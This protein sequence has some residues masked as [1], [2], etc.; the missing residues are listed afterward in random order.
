MGPQVPEQDT[1]DA[2]VR[3]LLT[4][5]RRSMHVYI[6]DKPVFYGADGLKDAAGHLI[7]ESAYFAEM[8]EH[9]LPM[10]LGRLRTPAAAVLERQGHNVTLLYACQLIHDDHSPSR[11]PLKLHSLARI[12]GLDRKVLHE[13]EHYRP[14]D[15]RA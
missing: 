9:R 11:W 13:F 5:G 12:F 8:E 6:P 7:P 15:R 10:R 14:Y 2:V 3:H 4:Q 1:F